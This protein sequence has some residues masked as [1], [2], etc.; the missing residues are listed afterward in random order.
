[1]D[2]STTGDVASAVSIK[3][4]LAVVFIVSACRGEHPTALSLTPVE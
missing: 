2:L 3:R 4:R 1:M